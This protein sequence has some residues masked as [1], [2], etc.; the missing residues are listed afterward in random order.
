[1]AG[2]PG[3]LVAAVVAVVLTLGAA[4]AAERAET[5]ARTEA[6]LAVVDAPLLA[7]PEGW[8]IDALYVTSDDTV[9]LTAHPRGE[10]AYGSRSV[11]VELSP[12]RPDMLPEPC[13]TA[14]CRP[15]DGD[16]LTTGDRDPATTVVR[17]LPHVDV[18]VTMY[19]S[20]ADARATA[21]KMARE[22]Q[23]TDARTLARRSS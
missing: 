5:R 13:R 9:H 1:M 20:G 16:L 3:G 18:I 4:A 12:S 6:E 8:V 2:H 19:R 17:R 11:N 23:P 15:L 21:V 7:P 14:G 10:Q 22:L